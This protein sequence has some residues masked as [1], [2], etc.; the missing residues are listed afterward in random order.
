MKKRGVKKCEK[1][2]LQFL[3]GHMRSLLRANHGAAA[4]VVVVYADPC[5]F[6]SLAVLLPSFTRTIL[7][8]HLRKSPCSLCKYFMGVIVVPGIRDDS[9]V[10][11]DS[12]APSQVGPP[13]LPIDHVVELRYVRHRRDEDL[14]WSGRR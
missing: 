9:L 10:L 3:T 5:P 12:C 14:S 6:P 7:C 11:V 13:L 1:M 4:F 2:I 8:S